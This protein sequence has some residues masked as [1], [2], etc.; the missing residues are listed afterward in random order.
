MRDALNISIAF[1]TDSGPFP[2]VGAISPAWGI[3]K[4]SVFFVTIWKA[5]A[6]ISGGYPSSFPWR[7][8]PIIPA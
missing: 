7:P 4:A 5:S 3:D 6:K 1:S 8:R 2:G